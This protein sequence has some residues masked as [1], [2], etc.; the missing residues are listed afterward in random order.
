M[1]NTHV[2]ALLLPP[3]S[4]PIA[5]LGYGTRRSPDG[6]A[7]PFYSTLAH[8]GIAAFMPSEKNSTLPL[9]WITTLQLRCHR[10]EIHFSRLNDRLHVEILQDR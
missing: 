3:L 7:N 6:H 10:F 5:R 9:L 4:E 1:T 8:R 2:L